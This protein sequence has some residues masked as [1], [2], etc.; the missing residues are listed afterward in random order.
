MTGNCNAF[1]DGAN[2]YCRADAVGSV[3]LKRLEDAEAEND[4][5]FGVI[6]G[7][8]TN[9]CGQTDSITRP[10]EGDQA[11]V[12]KRVMRYANYDPLDV[13]YIEMHVSVASTH[14]HASVISSPGLYNLPKLLPIQSKES[15]ISH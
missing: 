12:F 9:H 3:I 4:P 15:R 13:G 7:S 5:I 8:T 14:R 6:V 2:G 1:D 10:H 11:S